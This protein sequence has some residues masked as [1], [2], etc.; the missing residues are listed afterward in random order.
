MKPIFLFLILTYSTLL[1]GQNLLLNDDFESY[2]QGPLS[3]QNSGW[4]DLSNATAD[5]TWF[6]GAL[7][8]CSSS[9]ANQAYLSFISGD[10]IATEVGLN[11]VNG[12]V[13]V[14]MNVSLVS[15]FEIK[16][17]SNDIF[18]QDHYDDV[19][20]EYNLKYIID[21]EANVV[22]KYVNGGF[23]SASPIQIN[24][25]SLE[26][27]AFSNS[28]GNFKLNCIAVT[29]VTD[30]DHDGYFSNDDCND[31]N[32]DVN[33]GANEVPYDGQ[34]NDCNPSTPD[35]DLDGDGYVLANDCND[36]NGNI[37]PGETE[38]VY[39][40]ID[41]DC[42]PATKDDDLDGD[43][44]IKAND[45][46]DNN[47][48][49]NPGETE[50]AYNGIDDDCN[51]ATKD[52]DL[53]GDGYIKANDCNDNNGNVNPGETEIAY[54]GIDDDCNP[55]TKDDD[56]DG[57]GYNKANDCNDN[58]GNVNPGET[59][60]AYNGID[61]DCDP[62][63][64]DDDLD[65]DG[66]AAANDCD[67]KIA[68]INPGEAE[69]A[70]NGIDDDCD[71]FTP[72]DDLDE[73]GYFLS[74]DC[75]DNNE[76]INPG[77]D[78]VPGNGVD[79]N[80]NGQ[81]DEITATADFWQEYVKVSP[82]PSNEYISIKAVFDIKKVELYNTSGIRVNRYIGNLIDVKNQPPGWYFLIIYGENFETVVRPIIILR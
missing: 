13:A 12:Q 37:N 49:V 65:G 61:D 39:N 66:Y 55:A 5:V 34:D 72:D 44:Y 24:F 47:G 76:E 69:I 19:Q 14:E 60:I 31:N 46:N 43:G 82:N 36:A 3:N 74:D 79:D 1:T 73:D 59:E 62:F 40:G 18:Y 78:E 15:G 22:E 67:D 54:N 26:N 30:L 48:N 75:N 51:P 7:S 11:A 63:T 29:D 16:F 33:P 10:Y 6:G 28:Y 20:A 52:D 27:I 45:C 58:N 41:D 57:D 8:A 81:I 35:D 56:L 64:P 17:F 4:T 50:I 71:P 21:F 70:Y 80:C 77:A 53:D 38:V 23:I 42:N 25:N 2:A 68:E 32:P 9:D